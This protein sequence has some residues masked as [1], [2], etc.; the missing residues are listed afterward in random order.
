MLY[1]FIYGV[2]K[3]VKTFLFSYYIGPQNVV[4]VSVVTHIMGYC[5]HCS[6]SVYVQHLLIIWQPDSWS[7]LETSV[8]QFKAINSLQLV[9]LIPQKIRSWGHSNTVHVCYVKIEII[10]GKINNAR[11]FFSCTQL[12]LLFWHR[13][14]PSR[15]TY[16]IYTLMSFENNLRLYV[17]KKTPIPT[18]K[19]HF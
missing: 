2:Q 6:L 10:P 13:R 17:N 8:Y 4:H 11:C 12:L 5:D 1:T 19:L 14:I 7:L 9:H 16:S 18:T 15:P 3:C